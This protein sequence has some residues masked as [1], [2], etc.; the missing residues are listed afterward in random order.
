[1]RSSSSYNR[2]NPTSS[3]LPQRR[4]HSHF[5]TRKT[6]GLGGT[7]NEIDVT[8]PNIGSVNSSEDDGKEDEND[9]IIIHDNST[10]IL[11]ILWILKDLSLTIEL[12]LVAIIEDNDER[13]VATNPV[14]K[15]IW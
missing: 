3:L 7:S 10:E 12:K 5:H 14:T 8:S 2:L 6:R 4:S 11:N 15:W 13:F 1:M 9:S